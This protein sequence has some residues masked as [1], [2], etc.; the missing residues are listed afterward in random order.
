M[1]IERD[2]FNGPI[3]FVCDECGDTDDTHCEDF[4]GALA[5]FKSHG[6]KAF[7]NPRTDEWEH[8]CRDCTG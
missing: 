4:N 2:H 8:R 1:T 5:K 7:K 3:T 6:G